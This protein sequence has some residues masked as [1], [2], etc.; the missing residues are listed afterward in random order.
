MFLIASFSFACDCEWS[1]K[2]F[3]VSKFLKFIVKGKVIDTLYSF[4]DK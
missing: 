4:M 1:R 3:Y 2:L